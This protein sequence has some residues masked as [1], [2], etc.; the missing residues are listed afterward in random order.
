V[1]LLAARLFALTLAIVWAHCPAQAQTLQEQALEQTGLARQPAP[2]EWSV[3]LGGG[4]G[5]GPRFPGASTD[6]ARFAPL[7]EILYGKTLFLGINGLGLNAINTDHFRAGP[8]LGYEGGRREDVD[9]H[10]TGLGDIHSSLTAGVFGN[11]H[12]GG[13]D[14]G[15]TVRQ[16]ITHSGNGLTG[17]VHLDYRIPLRRE[18]VFFSFGP[19]FEF[20]NAEYNQRWFGVTPT[21]SFDSGLPVF[22]PRGG[23]KDVGLHGS[24]TH[25]FSQHLLL[26]ALVSFKDIVGDA[27]NSPIVQDR[28]Q[29]VVGVGLAYHF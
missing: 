28:T 11:Y 19:D 20:A 4:I 22:T 12:L 15:A 27:A 13:F 3:T 10:L 5:S 14:A 16:S 2:G 6:R 1:P 9:G 25:F 23:V 21:Q 29:V 17:L 7:I 26:R 24:A 18:R 8:V